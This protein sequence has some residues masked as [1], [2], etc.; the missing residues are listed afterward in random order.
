MFTYSRQHPP[1]W[2]D[3]TRHIGCDYMCD[4]VCLKGL[5]FHSIII[6]GQT[7]KDHMRNCAPYHLPNVDD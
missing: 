3:N 2:I 7:W 5:T 6:K 4:F 1:H